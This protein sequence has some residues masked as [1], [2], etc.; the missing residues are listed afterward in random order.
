M[1][2]RL[3]TSLEP[4]DYLREELGFPGVRQAAVVVEKTNLTLDT[5]A[6]QSE[7]L[8]SGAQPPSP[9]LRPS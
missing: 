5:G 6:L 2:R 1:T 4:A 7:R 8:V 9:T 3:W